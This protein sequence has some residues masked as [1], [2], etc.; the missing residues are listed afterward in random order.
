ML[1]YIIAKQKCWTERMT[2]IN[3]DKLSQPREVSNCLNGFFDNVSLKISRP[4]TNLG[5]THVLGD[6]M[7]FHKH[8][9]AVSFTLNKAQA[10]G[11]RS[12]DQQ[13]I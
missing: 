7:I 2:E 8:S 10:H 12:K 5:K 11:K 9:L 6:T 1:C 13:A 4:T 3:N